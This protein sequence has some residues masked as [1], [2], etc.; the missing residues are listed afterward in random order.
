MLWQRRFGIIDKF[1]DLSE[2]LRIIADI[3]ARKHSFFENLFG[4]IPKVV[5]AAARLLKV[6]TDLVAATVAFNAA[7]F[8]QVAQGLVET[9]FI[10]LR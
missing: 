7:A 6:A 2:F 1:N 8:N 9:V 4:F 3:E 5:Q 10:L